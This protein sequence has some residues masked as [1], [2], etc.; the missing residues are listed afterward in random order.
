MKHL[1]QLTLLIICFSLLLCGCGGMNGNITPKSIIDSDDPII[2]YWTD[3]MKKDEIPNSIYVFQDGKVREY[4]TRYTM[5]ELS[6]MSDT[7]IL[8]AL[9]QEYVEQELKF[10]QNNLDAMKKKADKY[11]KSI[12]KLS[13]EYEYT[14]V[15]LWDKTSLAAYELL[16]HDNMTYSLL[17]DMANLLKKNNYTQSKTITEDWNALVNSDPNENFYKKIWFGEYYNIAYRKVV[18][19]PSLFTPG[20]EAYD[21]ALEQVVADKILEREEKKIK[22][23]E[24]LTETNT[25]ISELET[26]LVKLENGEVDTYNRQV[27]INIISDESGNNVQEEQ[28]VVLG[29]KYVVDTL[30]LHP[31]DQMFCEQAIEVYDSKYYGYSNVNY[32]GRKYLFFRTKGKLK[33]DNVDTKDIYVDLKNFDKFFNK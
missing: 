25:Q 6:E 3:E 30:K 10:T 32:N 20:L 19:S 22:Y 26:K 9:K 27:I 17:S 29:K 13:K 15:D 1:K 8:S 7:E 4:D 21:K 2:G 12:D 31:S 16:E 24:K 28:L 11:Q 23:Q 5:G 18:G 14:W 33:F